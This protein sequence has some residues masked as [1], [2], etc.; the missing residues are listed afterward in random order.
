M[1]GPPLYHSA[2]AWLRD[3]APDLVPGHRGSTGRDQAWTTQRLYDHQQ[4]PFPEPTVNLSG[5][6][7]ADS[8]S[9]HNEGKHYGRGTYLEGD[10]PEKTRRREFLPPLF[11]FPFPF[12]P[13]KTKTKTVMAS[14]SNAQPSRP[15]RRSVSTK[16]TCPWRM[17]QRV[18]LH[19]LRESSMSM[20][21]HLRP[22][23]LES[24]HPAQHNTPT[25]HITPAKVSCFVGP[26]TV[27]DAQ[28]GCALTHSPSRDTLD[29]L[30]GVDKQETKHNAS[31]VKRDDS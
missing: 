21:T 2:S 26:G 20:P 12:P 23:N 1:D 18:M 13:T 4:L 22:R 14:I 28:F 7:N 25:L 29:M 9:H 6:H 30:P 10:I 27:H 8:H 31:P 5:S 11:P 3:P 17:P 19:T 16:E 15:R 24:P